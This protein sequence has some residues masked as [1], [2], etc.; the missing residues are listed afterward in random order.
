MGRFICTIYL[1]FIDTTD[2]ATALS[3]KDVRNIISFLDTHRRK[4]LFQN[5]QDG[6]ALVESLHDWE[7]RNPEII[8][9]AIKS[10]RPDLVRIARQ[11]DWDIQTNGKVIIYSQFLRDYLKSFLGKVLNI[12]LS[13][14][15]SF[16][17]ISFETYLPIFKFLTLANSSINSAKQTNKSIEF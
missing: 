7:E 9:Q 16:V 11:I 14:S 10:I 6:E 17:D 15:K 8:L 3:R 12:F 4:R 2:L 1:Q 13:H 5:V